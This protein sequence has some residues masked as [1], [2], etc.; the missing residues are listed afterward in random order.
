M[1]TS[2]GMVGIYSRA[3]STLHS[4]TVIARKQMKETYP[5]Q[6]PVVVYL[7]VVQGSTSAGQSLSFGPSQ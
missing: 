2:I 1:L 3:T 4:V 7:A 5:N 6:T